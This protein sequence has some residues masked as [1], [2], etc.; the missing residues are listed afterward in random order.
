[1]FVIDKNSN[2]NKKEEIDFENKKL[3]ALERFGNSCFW[4]LHFG[5]NYVS[6]GPN[7]ASL[8]ELADTSVSENR[9]IFAKLVNPQDWKQI[10]I[11]ASAAIREGVGTNFKQII[12]VRNAAN[13]FIKF[14][15]RGNVD[16]L[17]PSND[18]VGII[19]M[20]TPI[21]MQ[22]AFPAAYDHTINGELQIDGVWGWSRVGNKYYANQKALLIFGFDGYPNT[23]RDDWWM[24]Y[25]DRRDLNDLQT[26]WYESVKSQSKFFKAEFRLN[27]SDELQRWIVVRCSISYNKFN[28]CV[29][30]LSGSVTNI[31][32]DKITH[33]LLQDRTEQLQTIFQV[34]PDGFVTF[35]KDFNIKYAN[36]AFE[37]MFDLKLSK[38]IGLQEKSLID[39][40]Y[41]ISESFE[42]GY[43]GKS[44]E[45][46]FA[47]H[48]KDG[49]LK[50][51]INIKEHI[52]YIS[53]ALL[54]SKSSSISQILHL[55]DVSKE[56][57]IEEMKS[58][59]IATTAHELR[60]PMASI[61]GYSELLV[62]KRRMTEKQKEDC[63]E[64]IYEQSHRMTQILDDLLDLSRLE[65]PLSEHL[66][67]QKH[68]LSLIVENVI[69]TFAVPPNRSAPVI[70]SNV[71]YALVD[72]DKTHRILMNILSNAYK[73]SHN[74]NVEVV[75][76]PSFKNDRVEIQ[77]C[78]YGIGISTDNQHRLFER[79]FRADPSG[80]VPGTGLGLS[81]VKEL[82]ERMGGEIFITSTIGEGTK[83]SLIFKAEAL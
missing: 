18:E 33:E 54:K 55:R 27:P 1:L 11:G 61:L 36:Q 82:M 59:F 39:Y 50:F 6:V 71:A 26:R 40:I 8:L 79:F 35:D 28:G 9:D 74:G 63:L 57:A 17:S 72:A 64:S 25:V 41:S 14:E 52:K 19:G 58:R 80:N 45:D 15:L 46:L 29:D 81:I 65:S 4:V 43:L 23:D 31:T 83:V 5:D 47:K 38:L 30:K 73:Y 51:T 37:I 42:A 16:T 32:A 69:K 76:N 75:I 49:E 66:K 24:K 78:D 20:M 21:K 62:S 12:R 67:I 7:F 68:D 10:T 22:V 70:S 2:S 77:V 44:F 56:A 13:Q 60:T 3:Y 34:S 53:A 48:A